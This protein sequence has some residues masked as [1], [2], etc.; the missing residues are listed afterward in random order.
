MPKTIDVKLEDI[1]IESDISIRAGRLD[2]DTVKRYMDILDT[3]PPVII[4]TEGKG[5]TK[6]L[7]LADGFHRCEAAKRLKRETVKAE[8]HPGGQ[9]AAL[10]FAAFANLSHGRN[11][12][13]AER[14]AAIARLYAIKG[15][16]GQRKWAQ[17]A[18]AERLGMSQ[19]AVTLAL[20][21]A[22]GEKATGD[23]QA[24]RGD[25][26]LVSGL[27]DAEAQALLAL[28]EGDNWSRDELQAAVRTLEDDEVSAEYKTQML[29]GSVP[30]LTEGNEVPLATITRIVNTSDTTAPVR[31]LWRAMEGVSAMRAR[32]DPDAVAKSLADYKLGM[33]PAMLAEDIT[34]LESVA[35][36]FAAQAPEEGGADG[37]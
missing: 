4:Y 12:T 34:Y 15:E 16:D 35:A 33:L 22:R 9:E 36:A 20:K 8:I 31:P 10:E 17:R 6:V 19:Q 11:L 2:G 7:T 21:S 37:S 30:P 14:D 32:F 25:L 29:E 5:E 23:Q 24:S 1:R 26:A 13:L 18:L 3:M 27:E 28:K